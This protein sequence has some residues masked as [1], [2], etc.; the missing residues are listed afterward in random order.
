MLSIGP[1]ES[2][3]DHMFWLLPRFTASVLLFAGFLVYIAFSIIFLI[4]LV[5]VDAWKSANGSRGNR[6][7]PQTRVTLNFHELRKF[8]KYLWDLR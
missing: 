8:Y 2:D 1:K 4:P 3:I 5:I 6:P 7:S